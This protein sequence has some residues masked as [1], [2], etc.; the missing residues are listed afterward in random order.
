MK[1]GERIIID[2]RSLAEWREANL[3]AAAIFAR[4]QQVSRLNIVAKPGVGK[5]H[6]ADQI[7][8]SEQFLSTYDLILYVAPSKNILKE[9]L[10]AKLKGDKSVHV[11]ES[12]PRQRCGALDEEWSILERTGCGSFGK[13]TLCGNC[14]ERNKSNPCAWPNK[15]KDKLQGI[16]IILC[17]EQYFVVNPAFIFSIQQAT[18]KQKILVIFDEGRLSHSSF[19]V[20]IRRNDIERFA[21][22]IDAADEIDAESINLWKSN[23]DHLKRSDGDTLI[24]HEWTFPHWLNRNSFE[25]QLKGL[26]VY[27]K[28]FRYL[29]YLLPLLKYSR[30]NERWLDQSGNI[31]FIARPFLKN[32]DILILSAH[33]NAAYVSKRLGL[34]KLSS[35]FETITF[36]HSGTKIYNIKNSIGAERFFQSNHKQILDFFAAL[37]AR[38]IRN[39]KRTLLVVR[40]KFKNLAVSYLSKRLKD[41]GV[42]ATFITNNFTNSGIPSSNLIAVIHYGIV[43]VNDFT[44]YDCC[45]CLTSYYLSDLQLN[46]A[47]QSAEPELF[48][49]PLA[50][51]QNNRGCRVVQVDSK[52][53]L[54]DIVEWG[55]LYLR[56]LEV[57]PVLQAVARVR[58]YTKPREVILFQNHD[59]TD[60]LNAVR[61]LRTLEQAYRVLSLQ[62]ISHQIRRT[63]AGLLQSE[64]N[65][66]ASLREASRRVGFPKSTA[67]RI[68]DQL[69]LMSRNPFNSYVRENGT[70]DIGPDNESESKS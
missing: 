70:P 59:F 62:K 41:I 9:R 55:N 27:G 49:V 65:K 22:V 4:L 39:D 40:K 66:G 1:T 34:D 17:C 28:T 68:L 33:L 20:K 67:S 46:A 29:G 2:E 21:S 47:V 13:S 32:A 64:I 38:N 50:I 14:P 24:S 58:F 61:E 3:N 36:Q 53:S 48:R 43:G 7:L 51:R 5:S 37:I 30:P 18:K 57:D 54:S 52:Y 69:G 15:F 23:L 11:L 35:P 42:E 31:R 12:R 6:L 10:A 60:E 26:N 45:Y 44:D 16:K 56:I 8:E 19:E 63:K 25:V